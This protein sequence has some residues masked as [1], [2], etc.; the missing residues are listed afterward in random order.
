DTVAPIVAAGL[1]TDTGPSATDHATSNPAL[2]G[3]ADPGGKVIIRNGAVTLGTA[4]ADA[5]G[6][7]SFSPTGLLDR[8]YVLTSSDTAAAGSPGRGPVSFTLDTAAPAVPSAPDL[9]AA[10]D[11]GITTD[12]ITNVA[13][14]VFTGTAEANA[15]ITL[16]DGAAVVGSG[17]ADAAGNWSV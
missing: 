10:S 11:S 17:K 14:P 15:A 5:G 1:T 2:S 12:N 7:W 6:K 16:L 13:T 4:A 8:G 3:K 9:S